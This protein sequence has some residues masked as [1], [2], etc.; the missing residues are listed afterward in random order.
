[1]KEFFAGSRGFLVILAVIA[2]GFWLLFLMA[3][4]L[5]WL[6]Q[7]LVKRF[8]KDSSYE[9]RQ[10]VSGNI[11]TGFL[12]LGLAVLFITGVAMQQREAD[13]AERAISKQDQVLIQGFLDKFGEIK[14]IIESNPAANVYFEVTYK[15]RPAFAKA[16]SDIVWDQASFVDGHDGYLRRHPQ[17]A[18]EYQLLS[19]WYHGR[20][21]D[22]EILK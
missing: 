14:Q 10:A 7:V 20:A 13:E 15:T 5:Y 12:V 18:S 6:I 3:G 2:S 17:Y 1:M 8:C 9:E 21:L 16:L 19:N 11:L 4:V 22:N